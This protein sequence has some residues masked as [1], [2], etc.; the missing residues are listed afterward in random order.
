MQ[1]ITQITHFEITEEREDTCMLLLNM[2]Q[3]PEHIVPL[4]IQKGLGVRALQNARSELEE[5]F[6]SLTK[7]VNQ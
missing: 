5:I 4:L 7:G 3:S 2:T 6:L 1:G